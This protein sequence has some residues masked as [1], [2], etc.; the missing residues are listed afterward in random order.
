MAPPPSPRLSPAFFTS[1]ATQHL[2]IHYSYSQHTSTALTLLIHLGHAIESYSE[3]IDFYL[4]AIDIADHAALSSKSTPCTSRAVPP[5]P[6]SLVG[7]G[8]LASLKLTLWST[9][10]RTTFTS[11]ESCDS[12]HP[13][14]AICR[15]KDT[16]TRHSNHSQGLSPCILFLHKP[17]LG[18]SGPKRFLV[19]PTVIALERNELTSVIDDFSYG[20]PQGLQQPY[21]GQQPVCIHRHSSASRDR[22]TR[23]HRMMKYHT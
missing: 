23:Y 14:I 2:P 11:V 4:W 12:Y 10:P 19:L 22:C 1:S 18:P 5:L 16:I 21:Q 20:P 8:C 9:L 6:I 13:W 17:L 15:T 7:L 3:I